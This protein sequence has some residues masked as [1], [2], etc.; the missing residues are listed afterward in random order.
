[1]KKYLFLAL[2]M[3]PLISFAQDDLYFTRKAKSVKSTTAAVKRQEPKAQ[4][5]VQI[6]DYGACKRSDDDYNRRYVTEGDWQEAGG[7]VPDSL[8][9]DS[10]Q[11]TR[12]DMNDAEDDYRYSRRLIRFHSPRYYALSNPYYWDLV[13]G[14]GIYDYWYDD[15]WYYDP[16]YYSW[17]WGYGW[18]GGLWN[19]WYGPLWGYGPWY[20]YNYGYYNGWHDGYYAGWAGG[21]WGHPTNSTTFASHRTYDTRSSVGRSGYAG[22]GRRTNP[23]VGG[24]RQSSFASTRGGGTSSRGRSYSSYSSHI[25]NSIASSRAERQS[26]FSSRSSR[27]EANRDFNAQSRSTYQRNNTTTNNNTYS[28]RSSASRNTYSNNSN[29]SNTRSYTPP[30]TSS[31]SSSYGGSSGGGGSVRSS[32]GG[33]GGGVSRGGGGGRR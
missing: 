18:A 25:N 29:N 3:V 32:G 8:F 12:H 26:T 33:G 4:A 23:I 30:P 22:G 19:Y 5:P 7:N 11:V 10:I 31:S 2:M 27:S 9:V 13:Y 17:G 15:I 20:A 6:E 14:Y 1:M 21:G 28:S 24:S 16:F